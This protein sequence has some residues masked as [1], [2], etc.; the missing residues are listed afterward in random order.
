MITDRTTTEMRIPFPDCKWSDNI[1]AIVT[2][3]KQTVQEMRQVEYLFHDEAVVFLQYLGHV[4][5]LICDD[6]IK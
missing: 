1:S 3:L 6:T 4:L 5:E 2:V